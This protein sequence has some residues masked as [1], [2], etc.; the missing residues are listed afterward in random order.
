MRPNQTYKLLY[1]KGNHKWNEETTFG[2]G[3]NICKWC[4]Q[5][6]L[7]HQNI[8]TTHISPQQQNNPIEKLAE[9]L[10]RHFSKEYGWLQGTWKNAQH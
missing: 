5:Q 4:N 8:Q 1:S 2:L 10:N 9:D 6:G 3:E 7:N